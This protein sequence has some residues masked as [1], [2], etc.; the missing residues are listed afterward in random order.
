MKMNHL[1]TLNNLYTVRIV[2]A[3]IARL[4]TMLTHS[5]LVRLREPRTS[6]THSS[7]FSGS[8]VMGSTTKSFRT[9]ASIFSVPECIVIHFFSIVICFTA[10]L[11]KQVMC[12]YGLTKSGIDANEICSRSIEELSGSTSPV[13]VFQIEPPEGTFRH[14]AKRFPS[15]EGHREALI[16]FIRENLLD[17]GNQ[18]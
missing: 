2:S 14:F 5:L 12:R 16:H 17:E 11:G 9:N 18:C 6:E 15:L 8:P 1:G 7:V 10:Y 13:S 3:R 4:T